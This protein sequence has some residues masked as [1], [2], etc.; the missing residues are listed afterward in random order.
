M[1]GPN[2]LAVRWTNDTGSLAIQAFEASLETNYSTIH[3][4]NCQ[5]RFSAR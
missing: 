3:A 1:N 4:K 5:R 2:P